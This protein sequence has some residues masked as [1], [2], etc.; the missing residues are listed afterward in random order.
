[1]FYSARRLICLHGVLDY[2]ALE[3]MALSF[4]SFVHF[5]IRFLHVM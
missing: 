5:C 1:M 2:A 4:I 3:I